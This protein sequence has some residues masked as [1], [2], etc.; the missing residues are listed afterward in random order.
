[1]KH[2]TKQEIKFIQSDY[3]NMV[4]NSKIIFNERINL[5]T[6]INL[7]QYQGEPIAVLGT[8][9][10]GLYRQSIELLS[11]QAATNFKDMILYAF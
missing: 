6:V 4:L 5:S 11:K 10:T 3:G 9:N 7:K 8:Q 2:P 1:M